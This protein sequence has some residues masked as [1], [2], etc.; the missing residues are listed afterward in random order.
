MIV[1]MMGRM[2][3]IYA[4]LLMGGVCVLKVLVVPGVHNVRAWV[5]SSLKTVHAV[6]RT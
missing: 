1:S 2:E 3:Y 6:V 5:I 4:M